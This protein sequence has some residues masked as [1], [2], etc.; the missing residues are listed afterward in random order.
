MVPCPALRPGLN[1]RTGARCQPAQCG[2]AATVRIGI[3]LAMTASQ[4]RAAIKRLGLTQRHA[5]KLLGVDI[6]TSARWAAGD[7]A[8]PE[9]V[10]L[11]LGLGMCM[12]AGTCRN[13]KLDFDQVLEQAHNAA[14]ARA[15]RRA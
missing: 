15:R 8:I 12:A 10:A 1:R 5:A 2:L 4:Y 3:R 7:R 14:H 11:V 6:R 9:S 13:L